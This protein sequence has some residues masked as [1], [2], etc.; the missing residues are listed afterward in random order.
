M[1]Y[2]AHK[3][4]DSEEWLW[5][6][7]EF[8]MMDTDLKESGKSVRLELVLHKPAGRGPFPLFVMNHG[9]TGTGANPK[10]FRQT[11]SAPSLARFFVAR[12]WMVAFPQRRGRGKSDGLYDEGFMPDRSRYSGDPNQCLLGAERALTDIAAAIDVLRKRPDVQ[13]VPP[14]IGGQSRGGILSIAYA[15]KHP[16]QVKGVMNFVGGWTGAWRSSAAE[17][18]ATLFQQGANFPAPTLWLYGDN[19]PVYPLTHSKE[20][21]RAFQAA[22]GKGKFVEFREVPELNGHRIIYWPQLWKVPVEEYLTTI[23]TR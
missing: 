16:Q 8:L 11:W 10:V 5:G 6:T 17:V 3:A 22:G 4:S 19:D 15:G 1:R 21:F 18:N 12:G 14:L 20:S 23:D 2:D 13:S 7:G 9:S